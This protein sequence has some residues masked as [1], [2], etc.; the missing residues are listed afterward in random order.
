MMCPID[1]QPMNIMLRTKELIILRCKICGYT[2]G[3][4]VK[5]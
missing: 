4:K 2:R 3:L 1:K 5:K